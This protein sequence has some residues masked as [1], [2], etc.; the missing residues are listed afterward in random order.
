MERT[1][2]KIRWITRTAVLTAMLVA[3]QW[4]T[5]GTQA[6]AGQYITGSLVNCVLVM[7]AMFAGFWNGIAVALLSPLC[8]FLLGI[9]PVLIQLVPC[10]ALGNCVYVALL[11]ALTKNWKLWKGALGVA[12]AATAKFLTLYVA[13]V[14]VLIPVMGEALKAPQV[15]RFT[16]MFSIPQLIT[17]LAG[18]TLALLISPLVRKAIQ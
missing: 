13:V 1:N 3:V 15:Q 12:V 5:A 6:F 16:A 18:G 17:A 11:W 4:A 10:I 7:A 9:G 2:N 14:K 8:A